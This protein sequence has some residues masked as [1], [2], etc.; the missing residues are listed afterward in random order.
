MLVLAIDPG[1]EKCGLAIVEKNGLILDRKIVSTS[2]LEQEVPHFLLKWKPQ[3]VLLGDGTFSKL[4][5]KIVTPLLGQV[6]LLLVDEKNSTYL[7]RKLY[8]KHN[9]PKGI[10]RFIPLGLQVPPEPYDDFAA[11]FMALRYFEENR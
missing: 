10:W 3:T 7:A 2:K 11:A 9:P 6:P 5:Q 1:R 4:V 8:F